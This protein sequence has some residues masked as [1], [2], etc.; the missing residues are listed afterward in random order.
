MGLSVQQ[1]DSADILYTNVQGLTNNF[2]QV[3]IIA[4][5][6]KPKFIILSETHMTEQVHENE[7]S[8]NGYNQLTSVSISTRTGGVIIY[9][10][11]EWKVTKLFEKVKNSK[12]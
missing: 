5:T 7:I 9:Y 11:L 10:K 6:E 12:Y 4:E 1:L 3:E 2:N 8:L